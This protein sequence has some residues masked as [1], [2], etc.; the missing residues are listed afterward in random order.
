MEPLNL[1]DIVALLVS[2]QKTAKKRIPEDTE[3]WLE[4]SG[5]VHSQT[6][7]ANIPYNQVRQKLIEM[8]NKLIN[9][10]KIL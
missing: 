7:I 6:G 9:N 10:Q 5:L 3:L 1:I 4:V 2:I 8:H